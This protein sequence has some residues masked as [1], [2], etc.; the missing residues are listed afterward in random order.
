VRNEGKYDADHNTDQRHNIPDA[1]GHM[2]YISMAYTESQYFTKQFTTNV[3]SL[4][5]AL[6]RYS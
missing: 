4:G 5:L 6:G 1:Q 3:G 2:A